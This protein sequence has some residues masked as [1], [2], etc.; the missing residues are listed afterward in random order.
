M[1]AIWVEGGRTLHG[2]VQI[3]GS[4]NA[5]LPIMA[6]AVLISGECVLENCPR[7]A[8][9]ECM[10]ALLRGIGCK[11]TRQGSEI[12][13]NAA[14]ITNSELP[15]EQMS[16][17]RS[18]VM[19]MGPLLARCGEV[20]LYP[21][22]GCVIGDRPIDWH[23]KVLEQLGVSCV[24]MAAVDTGKI[25]ARVRHLAGNRIRLPFPSVGA[26]ENAVMAAVCADGVTMIENCAEEPEIHWLCRFLKTAG[27][28]LAFEAGKIRIR[29]NRELRPCRF[30]IPS[31]RIVTGTYLCCALAAGG[32]I[33][34]RGAPQGE[35]AALEA[36][37]VRMGMQLETDAE[38]MRL[39][40]EKLPASPGMVQT[41]IYPGFPTDLQSP[42]L[43]ALCV[44]DG[45][46]V[47]EER[48]FN[49]RF[50][51]AEELNRMGAGIRIEG[52][53]LLIPGQKKLAGMTVK[54][55]DL[56]G[57]AALVTAGVCAKG[58][59]VIEDCYHIE[60][61]YEDICRDL[62]RLGAVIRS[63]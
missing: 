45:S 33:F 34:L 10:C 7:I 44:A 53:R 18:S 41:E 58:E 61:G 50:G 12:R 54:A 25:S 16:K 42:L 49:G 31:D 6:A 2:E 28:D 59:T 48:I 47:V 27:A 8:D 1:G 9:V 22:G 32:R 14:Q 43:P 26:T 57:G 24:D 56:R 35:N 21:P 29:G 38:G 55:G 63:A 37:A 30:R 13:I 40:M 17:M 62:R 46:C 23:L 4:K 5:A 60:R 20:V 19:L 36:V 51:A 39:K 15:G 52:N 11:V 3:Q